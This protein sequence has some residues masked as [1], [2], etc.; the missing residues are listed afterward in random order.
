[1]VTNPGVCEKSAPPR[2]GSA[3]ALL[4][5]HLLGRL[6]AHDEHAADAVAGWV[7]V[8]RRFGQFGVDTPKATGV[9]LGAMSTKPLKKGA[10][11]DDL[12]EV[13][14]HFVAEIFDG[15]LYAS[16]RPAVR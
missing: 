6:R 8:T 12:C 16:P 15:E 10:T 4:G 5:Q 3:Q 9:R 1:M 7:G 11:Y 13:P 14:D 2:L